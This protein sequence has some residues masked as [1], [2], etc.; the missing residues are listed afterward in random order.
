MTKYAEMTEEQRE[1]YRENARR[2]Y[3]KNREEI[4]EKNKAYYR[5]VRG[6]K[7]F[8]R[9]S[10]L[11]KER[12]PDYHKTRYEAQKEER[13]ERHAA[14]RAY[15]ADYKAERGCVRC[16]ETDPIVLEFHHRNPAEKEYDAAR[17]PRLSRPRLDAELAKCDVVCA[18]C[19]RRIHHELKNG[20]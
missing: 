2:Y 10:K 8:E 13:Q 19:H 5:K 14:V 18:N 17:F 6:T 1:R 9:R 7:E 3:Q 16:G 20:G 15:V 4:I 12:N 11:W